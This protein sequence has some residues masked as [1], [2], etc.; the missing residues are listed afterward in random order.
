M[1]TVNPLYEKVLVTIYSYAFVYTTWSNVEWLLIYQAELKC[2][3]WHLTIP[4]ND[5]T[6][7]R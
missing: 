7:E 2:F 6:D 1:I 5:L 4:N 3:S